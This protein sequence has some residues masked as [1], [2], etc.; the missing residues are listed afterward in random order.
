MARPPPLN[1]GNGNGN[2][3]FLRKPVGNGNNNS[4]PCE[5]QWN[6]GVG[7][8]RDS[9]DKEY[10]SVRNEHQCTMQ[11]GD[12]FLFIDLKGLR[13]DEFIENIPLIYEK[14]TDDGYYTWLI[15]T[16]DAEQ[17][18]VATKAL[19]ILE[20][21]TIHMDIAKRVNAK[22]IHAAGELKVDG[23]SITFNLQSGTYMKPAMQKKGNRCRTDYFEELV[24]KKVKMY[25]GDN[26][27]DI[28]E[29]LINK[30]NLPIT[31]EELALYEEYGALITKYDSFEAC[32][33]ANQRK[34]GGS[35]RKKRRSKRKTNKRVRR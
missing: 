15:Y 35:T 13:R 4:D 30:D 12:K 9:F 27:K 10:I 11:F 28:E 20:I 26:A 34:N 24:I 3:G 33:A 21:G 25:L 22:K 5:V 1:F 17:L 14:P 7:Y 8:A 2:N 32:K 6:N 16:E 23:E 29:S 18:F 31:G 19:S